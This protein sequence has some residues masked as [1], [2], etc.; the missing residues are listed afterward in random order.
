MAVVHRATAQVAYAHIFATPFPLEEAR[1]RWSGHRG[2]VWLARRAG[3]LVGFAA[4]TDVELDGLY[5]LPEERGAGIGSAL[6]TAVGDV[7]QLWVLEQN[8]A[9]RTWYERRGW[10]SSGERQPAYGVWDVRYL[11]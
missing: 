10:R 2:R 8:H 6:L 4:A 5:V 9:A 3:V 7:R 11:R 1:A